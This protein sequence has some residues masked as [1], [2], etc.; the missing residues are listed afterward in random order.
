VYLVQEPHDC[1]MADSSSSAGT[2]TG[3][4]RPGG[5]H[6]RPFDGRNFPVWKARIRAKLQAAGLLY[7]LDEPQEAAAFSSSSGGSSSGSS[8]SAIAVGDDGGS[9]APREQGVAK[10]QARGKRRD[11]QEADQ[12]RVYAMLVL[13]LDDNHVAI[14]TSEA[15]EGDCAAA[16]RVLL[17]MYERDSTATKHHLR[18]E[19]H[20][21]RLGAGESIEAYKARVLYLASRLRSMKEHVS[22]GEASYCLLEGLPKAYDTLRQTLE[23]QDGLTFEQMCSYL[24]DTQ[25]KMKARV[26]EEQ[27]AA[28]ELQQLELNAVGSMPTGPCGL[29]KSQG[30]WIG[31]C[32]QRKGR[33]KGECFVCGG[34][35][36]GWRQCSAATGGDRSS[37]SGSKPG[38][39]SLSSIVGGRNGIVVDGE[40][41]EDTFDGEM[42]RKF[43][44]WRNIDAVVKERSGKKSRSKD[45]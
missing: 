10:K 2:M 14:V 41:I 3:E 43:G 23:V 8:T 7:V 4:E 19:L 35:G 29:C 24:R 31:Q 45:H 25:D 6:V 44:E 30:H 13:A 18:R 38:A 42:W 15:Q 20:R 26:R 37:D 33:Q 16:W 34:T 40:F 32:P 5:Q 12:Q 28:M 39:V 1:G 17:R 9:T 21:V 11:T 22:E 27:L 36:H